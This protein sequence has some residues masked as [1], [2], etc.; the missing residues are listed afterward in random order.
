M[1]QRVIHPLEA[2]EV[3]EEQRRCRGLFPLG[4]QPFNLSAKAGAVGKARHLVKQ[5]ECLDMV[6]IGADLT[7]QAGHRYGQIG[8]LDG[9]LRR[10]GRLQVAVGSGDQPFGCDINGARSRGDCLACRRPA[11]CAAQDRHDQRS[12]DA[13]DVVSL[14]LPEHKRQDEHQRPRGAG[15]GS[16]AAF[17]CHAL[18]VPPAQSVAR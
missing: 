3:D 13:Q 12:A 11:Q 9:D 6:Q 7:E 5:C 2:V 15:E 14:V 4:K 8:Q 17:Q 16:G 1:A 10:Y 18:H